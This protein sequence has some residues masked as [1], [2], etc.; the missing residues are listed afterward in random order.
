MLQDTT[1]GQTSERPIAGAAQGSDQGA[2]QGARRLVVDSIGT[3]D[4][5][6]VASVARGLR[7]APERVAAALYRAPAV[8]ADGLSADIATRMASLLAE[9]GLSVR[10]DDADSPRPEAQALMDVAIHMRDAR[11]LPSVAAL[12]GRFIGA[13][14]AQALAQLTAPPGLVLGRVS[15]ATADALARRLAE[16][17]AEV[18]AAPLSDAR[19]DLI[20]DGLP[21]ARREAV[22]REAG[23]SA[24]PAEAFPV[25]AADLDAA[26]ADQLWRRHRRA[27]LRALD[28][29]FARYDLVLTA[30]AATAAGRTLLIERAGVPAEILETVFA[31]LPITLV[32]GLGPEEAAE[33]AALYRAA[34][35]EAAARLVTFQR[36]H[37]R[38]DAGQDADRAMRA[39]KGLGLSAETG[40]PRPPYRTPA[41]SELEARFARAVL[42]EAGVAVRY[43]EAGP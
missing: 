32:E 40:D 27:E 6:A 28:R 39:L 18:V 19:Y 42:E 5:V 2:D 38:I 7:V 14:H 15:R 8:L 4:A 13:S 26:R 21:A 3:A 20:D 37:L 34:G 33:E 22:R 35:L 10:I 25:L 43:E 30:P 24:A 29:R 9:I 31:A 1:S 17:P 16:E 41:L 36:L 12:V 11:R 23:A